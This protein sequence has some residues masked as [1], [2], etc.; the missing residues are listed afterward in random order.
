MNKND[1]NGEEMKNDE[2]DTIRRVYFTV[3]NLSLI[4]TRRVN[5]YVV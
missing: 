2:R 4:C 5:N 1:D 3:H